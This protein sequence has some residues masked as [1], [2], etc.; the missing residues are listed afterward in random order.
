MKCPKLRISKEGLYL[1]LY[2]SYALWSVAHTQSSTRLNSVCCGFDV[3]ACGSIAYTVE[4]ELIC[5]NC[6]IIWPSAS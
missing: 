2:V 4:S 1:T 6:E 5:Q 3:D